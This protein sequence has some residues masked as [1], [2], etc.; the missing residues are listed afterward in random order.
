MRRLGLAGTLG[1]GIYNKN[2]QAT[3]QNVLL[4]FGLPLVQQVSWY[5]NNRSGRE[6]QLTWWWYP[7]I[8]IQARNVWGYLVKWQISIKRIFYVCHISSAIRLSLLK[9]GSHRNGV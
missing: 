2:L 5:D 1:H 6:H 7:G 9:K 3:W 8:P 4:Y